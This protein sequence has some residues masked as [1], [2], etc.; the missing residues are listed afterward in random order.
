[1]KASDDKLQEFFTSRMQNNFHV[2]LCMSKTGD[3]LRNYSRMY[4][5]LV[6]NTTIVWFL[7]WPREALIEV[8]NKYLKETTIAEDVQQR[9]A[10][11][12]GDTH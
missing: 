5:G 2:M 4:P 6:N 9:I 12:F 10:T 7:S 3:N 11:F 1:M 8:A